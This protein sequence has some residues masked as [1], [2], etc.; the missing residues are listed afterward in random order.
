MD[1]RKRYVVQF[2]YVSLISLPTSSSLNHWWMSVI[3]VVLFVGSL[4]SYQRGEHT[5]NDELVFS[6]HMG[7]VFHDSCGIECGSTEEL[8]TLREFI[9][10][11]CAEK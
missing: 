10:C 5:I 8:D 4:T 2:L 9:C 7:Y 6:N 1:K 11:K 3:L